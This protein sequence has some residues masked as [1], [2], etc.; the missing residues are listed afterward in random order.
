MDPDRSVADDVK[1]NAPAPAPGTTPEEIDKIRKHGAEDFRANVDDDPEKAE[2]WLENSIREE[3]RKKYISQRFIDKKCKEFLELKQGWMS[4]AEYEREFVRL[5]KYAQE[6]VSTEAIMCKRFEEGLNEDIRLYAGL[7]ELKE[8]VVLV[9]RACKAEELSK[10][11]RKAEIEARD[12]RKRSMSKTFQPQPKKL[13]EMNLRSTGLAGYPR[14]DRGKTYSRAKT[15]A[16]SVAS[17]GNMQN[18]R[19]ECQQCGRRHIGECWGFKRSYFKCGS[20]EHYIKDCTERIEEERLQSVGSGETVSRGRP[21]RNFG[22]K[23]SGKSVVKDIAGRSEIRAPAR[24]NCRQKILELKCENGGIL[25]VEA[26]EPNKLPIAISYMSIQKCMRKRCEAYLA[27]VLNTGITGSKLES[28]SI[29]CEFP[30]VFPEELPR[31]PPIREVEF[32]IDLLLEL[33]ARPLFLQQ[34]RE[35]HKID[36]VNQDSITMDFV[37]GLPLTPWKKDAIWVIVDR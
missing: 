22:S 16:T 23:V 29:V 5:S 33:R 30:D 32:V 17:V 4:V 1:S 7:L 26:K 2:F 28:V 13:K 12:V 27:Y 34:I 19:P 10:E 36:S 8:F 24:V 37:T 31:L 20:E 15:Q 21:P 3:F 25:R 18:T 35:A 14:K 11:K 6:C 9:D